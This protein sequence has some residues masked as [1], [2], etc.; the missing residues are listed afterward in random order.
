MNLEVRSQNVD[1]EDAL[2][3]YIERRIRFSLSRFGPRVGRVR[4]RLSDVNGPRGGVDKC[5]HVSVQVLPSGS[6]VVEETA[7]SLYSAIDRAADRLGQCFS[8]VLDRARELRTRRE[9]VRTDGEPQR[10]P[11]LGPR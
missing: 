6:V 5:C 7:L 8:R 2:Q 4:V 1:L 11:Y 9:S 3:G 10:R